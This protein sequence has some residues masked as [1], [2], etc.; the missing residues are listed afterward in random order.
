MRWLGLSAWVWLLDYLTKLWAIDRL[1]VYPI[2]VFP[3]LNWS[4]GYNSGA[5]FGIL[6]DGAAWQRLLL[7]G[8]SLGTCVVFT[9]WLWRIPP[10]TQR[11][12]SLALAL[13]L[14]G[15]AGNL[16]ERIRYGR[17]TDFIDVYIGSWH[18]PAFNI[19]DSAITVGA[20]IMMWCLWHDTPPPAAKSGY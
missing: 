7:I 8:I 12:L 16:W 1:S 14:G 20:V 19:A 9:I 18:W 13:L 11:R 3:G 6:A 10:R 4:L 5:A 17:V 2:K 15:A